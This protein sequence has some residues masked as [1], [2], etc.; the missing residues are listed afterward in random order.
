MPECFGSAAV[1]QLES[2]APSQGRQNVDSPSDQ[3]SRG[4][5]GQM[6]RL[7]MNYMLPLRKETQPAE[8]VIVIMDIVLG[9]LGL[10]DTE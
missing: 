7:P 5:D 9:R 3:H 10:Q 8:I 2:F 6:P 1:V 4:P